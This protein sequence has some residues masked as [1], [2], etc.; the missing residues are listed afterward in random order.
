MGGV[1]PKARSKNS[2]KDK[3]EDRN[4][5]NRS[6]DRPDQAEDGSL[7][8][9]NQF[10]TCE[11]E[12]QIGARRQFPQRPPDRAPSCLSGDHVPVIVVCQ[13][14]VVRP[15]AFG[16]WPWRVPDLQLAKSEAS[17]IKDNQRPKIKVQRPKA[18]NVTIF[19]PCR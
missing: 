3:S 6:E 9:A 7:V 11:R 13:L 19:A 10:A 15:L 5:Y 4:H 16:F 18:E 1:C 17:M 14:S 12:N 8:A 2:G